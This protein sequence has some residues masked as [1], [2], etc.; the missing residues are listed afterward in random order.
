VR[1]KILAER[2]E[3]S[4]QQPNNLAILNV[5]VATG[6]TSE[7]LGQFGKVM[8]VEYDK[9]CYEFTKS[10]LSTPIINGSILE[11]PFEDNSYDLVCAFDV[12]EHVEDDAKA[13][14]EMVRVCKPNS[15]V[16]ITV[17]TFMSLWGQHDVIN[18]HYRRYVMP[19]L[20]QLFQAHEGKIVYKSYFNS[21]L[22]PPIYAFRN[23]MRILPKN[24]FR[25]KEGAGSDHDII[26]KDSF[27]NQILETVFNI[28]KKLLHQNITFPVGVSAVIVWQK[29]AI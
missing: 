1:S 19:Q 14:A 24:L 29:K 13:V 26:H 6:A 16:V 25:K 21:L 15:W 23:L 4:C 28:E 5:G 20:T 27:V 3:A 17:P 8:S 12:I 18:H 7:M 2:I 11:L 9:D 10:I 22:F